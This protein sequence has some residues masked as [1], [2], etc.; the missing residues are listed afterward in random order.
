MF[1]SPE[2]KNEGSFRGKRRIEYMRRVMGYPAE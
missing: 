1:P 2:C